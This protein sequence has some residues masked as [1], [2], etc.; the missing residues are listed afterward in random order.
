M[1]IEIAIADAYGAGFEFSSEK[2]WYF[3][4]ICL[5]I[6]DMIYMGSQLNIPMIPR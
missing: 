4:M 2:K 3:I 5:V 1:L 6:H